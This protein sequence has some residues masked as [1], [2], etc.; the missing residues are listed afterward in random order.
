MRHI[1]LLL[2]ILTICLISTTATAQDRARIMAMGDSFFAFYRGSGQSIPDVVAKTLKRPVE[3]R[4]VSGARIIYKLP[5]SGSMG[6]N[7]S[8]QYRPGQWEWV[9]LNGGGNDLWLGCGC[10]DC[11]RKMDKLISKDGTRGEI[12]RLV[13]KVRSGNS[14]VIY[15]GY[16]RSPGFGSPIENCRDDGD[17]LERRLTQMAKRDKGVWFVPVKDMVKSGDKSFHAA[18]RVHPSIKASRKIGQRI[19]GVIA[20]NSR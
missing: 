4:A 13:A 10:S 20:N 3:N 15:A 16:L 18:D 12:P 2:Q 8:K 1:R 6:F 7:I 14:R 5:L 17:E 19:A 11:R 9:I